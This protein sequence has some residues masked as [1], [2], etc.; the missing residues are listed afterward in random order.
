M[1]SIFLVMDDRSVS[2]DDKGWQNGADLVE[3]LEKAWNI[4]KGHITEI[5][6]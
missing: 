3:S 1:T 6:D 5:E 4:L 2:S